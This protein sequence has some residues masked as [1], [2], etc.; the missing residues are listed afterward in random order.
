MIVRIALGLFVIIAVAVLIVTFPTPHDTAPV[1]PK[2]VTVET[3]AKKPVVPV[4]DIYK[5]GTHT[6]T[7]SLDLPNPCSTVSVESML[8]GEPP[9]RILILLTVLTDEG[10]C[11][12]EKTA[13]PFETS[14]TAPEGVP[15]RVLVNGSEASVTSR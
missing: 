2:P 9:E 1:A 11:V 12:Q 6:I 3:L 4:R 13:T 7:G 5:K 14:L 10:I 8:E 15:L